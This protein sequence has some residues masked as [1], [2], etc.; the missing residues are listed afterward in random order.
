MS[1]HYD[2]VVAGAGPADA[3]CARDLPQRE[4][5]VLVLEAEPEDGLLKQSNK[6][7]AETFA[8]MT[9]GCW[10]SAAHHMCRN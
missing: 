6:P 5:D 1:E 9:N 4:C 2:V 3:Q 7:A 10:P 8:S